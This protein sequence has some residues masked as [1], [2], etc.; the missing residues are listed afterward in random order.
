MNGSWQKFAQAAPHGVLI[1]QKLAQ[2]TQLGTPLHDYSYQQQQL[3]YAL[4]NFCFWCLIFDFS[5]ACPAHPIRHPI[6]R[7]QLAA[8]TTMSP[9]VT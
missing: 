7:F 5:K 8:T 1:F 3:C 9:S 2:R 4:T 6:A